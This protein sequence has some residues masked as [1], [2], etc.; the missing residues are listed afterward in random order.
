MRKK[1]NYSM[2]IISTSYTDGDSLYLTL[3]DY[4]K[5]YN[6]LKIQKIVEVIPPNFNLNRIFLLSDN[7]EKNCFISTFIK[8][9]SLLFINNVAEGSIEKY[10][11]EK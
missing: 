2:L 10:V 3:R 11:I 9:N 8:N 6:I 1:K 7:E 5:Y 4:S